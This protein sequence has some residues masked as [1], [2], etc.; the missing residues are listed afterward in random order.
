MTLNDIPPL[1]AALNATATVL[2]TAGFVFIKRG[3]REEHKVT[4]LC[5]GVISAL[6]LVGYV[7]HKVLKGAAAGPGEALVGVQPGAGQNDADGRRSREQFQLLPSARLEMVHAARVQA[8]P[9]N[10]SGKTEREK[11]EGRQST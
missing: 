10:A 7:T 2:I 5:A 9:L 6:F 11:R 3:Q 4:M 8:L 1:N